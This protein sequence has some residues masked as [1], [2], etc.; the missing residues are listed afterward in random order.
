MFR[1]MGWYADYI[2]EFYPRLSKVQIEIVKKW[3]RENI[4]KELLSDVPKNEVE[5]MF[6]DW[7]DV[8]DIEGEEKG[9]KFHIPEVKYGTPPSDLKK[10][11]FELL[12]NPK[13]PNLYGVFEWKND[14]IDEKDIKEMKE[15]YSKKEL[16]EMDPES[17]G[18][19]SFSFDGTTLILKE[20]P[21]TINGK[22][23][24]I[25]STERLTLAD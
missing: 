5:K 4:L 8:L 17:R 23:Y 14:D 7:I 10:E 11:F 6:E 24:L 1:K 25:E 20:K 3:I 22:K 16:E 19:D 2:L 15:E 21:I 12:M 13:L 18:Y 9:T